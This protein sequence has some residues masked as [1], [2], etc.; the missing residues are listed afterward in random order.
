M[1]SVSEQFQEP[2]N[3]PTGKNSTFDPEVLKIETKLEIF[4]YFIQ[5]WRIYRV[6]EVVLQ[7]ENTHFNRF[8]YKIDKTTTLL[9]RGFDRG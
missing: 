7:I 5:F 9:T 3:V 6:D 4:F 8:L 2:K 1:T